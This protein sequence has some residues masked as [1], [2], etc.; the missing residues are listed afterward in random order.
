MRDVDEA[1]ICVGPVVDVVLSLVADSAASILRGLQPLDVV[2]AAGTDLFAAR[3]FEMR[4]LVTQR[5]GLLRGEPLSLY[6]FDRPP[7]RRDVYTTR[8]FATCMPVSWNF[9][10]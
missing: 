6:H 8:G 2:G 10:T 9:S 4:E 5:F 7:R 3:A 1:T